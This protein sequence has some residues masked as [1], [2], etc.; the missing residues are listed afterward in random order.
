MKPSTSERIAANLIVTIAALA[1]AVGFAWWTTLEPPQRLEPRAP[2]A[3]ETDPTAGAGGPA[4]DLR[5]VFERFDGLPAADRTGRWPRFRGEDFSNIARRQPPLRNTW[6]PDGPPVEWAL[7]LGEGHAGPIVHDGRVILLDYDETRHAD[8]LRCF[9]LAD[10]REIWRRWYQVR[11]K[12]NHGMSRTVPAT[13]GRFVVSIGPKCHVLCVDADDGAF[14]WGI[15]LVRQYAT[16]VPLWYTGQCPVIDNG[17]AILA[18]GGSSLLMAVDCATGQVVWETPNPDAWQMSHA[19]VMPMDCLGRRAWVYTA[20]GGTVAVA[21]DGDDRGAVL[22]KSTAWDHAVISPSPVDLG[23]GK[24]FLTAG[25]G[26]GSML[27]QITREGRTF[28][29]APVYTLDKSRFAC[30]QQTPILRDGHLYTILTNDAGPARRQFACLRPDDG[31]LL[32]T[33]GKSERFGLGPFLLVDDRALILDDDGT[34]TMARV[35]PDGYTMMA[36]AKLLDGR[37]AW[38]PMA[39]VDGRLLLRDWKR[40]LCLD[41]RAP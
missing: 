41:L 40:M 30:E 37:D 9:S 26:V 33:S 4:V 24:L 11:I 8:A 22:W 14:R 25:Y 17:L 20:L 39:L 29:A 3:A 10:G 34:L 18:P 31:T 27:L 19:S 7:D 6:P 28:A 38:A 5:G 15:D 21:A 36:R 1:A 35:S 12:R 2:T 16:D 23:D 32:W 13:D